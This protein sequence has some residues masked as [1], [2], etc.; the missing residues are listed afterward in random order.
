MSIEQHPDRRYVWI[1]LSVIVLVTF[2]VYSR[3]LWNGYTYDDAV[4]V[5]APTSQGQSNHMVGELQ[6]LSRYFT[7]VYG[8][9][10][11]GFGRG[12]RPVTVLSYALVHWAF[13]VQDKSVTGGW[14]CPAWPH[15]AM[16][17]LLHCVSVWLVYLF[18]AMFV[19][20]ADMTG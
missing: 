13:R 4:F 18:V 17:V 3:S 19:F 1:W 5:Q 8:E 15:H 14:R 7:S 2:G 11:Q 12:L 6:P 16:N 20:K 9:G 10:S